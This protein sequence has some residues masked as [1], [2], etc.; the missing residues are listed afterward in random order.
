MLQHQEKP[1]IVPVCEQEIGILYQDDCLV[2][3]DKPDLLLSIP[4]KH[5]L[6]RDSVLTRL[7]EQ[8]N[9]VNLVHRLDL[10]TSG[11]LVAALSKEY[12]AHLSAQFAAR[13]VDKTYTAVLYG[14]LE[15]SQ[16]LIDLPIIAD[17]PNRPLQKI[18]F[19]HGKASQTEYTLLHYDEEKNASRVL[20]K[21]ITGRTHQ[22][23][24]HAREIGHP[25][26]GCD[27]YAHEQAYRQSP[28]L[29]L[30]ANS[31]TFSHPRTGERMNLN[32]NVPF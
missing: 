4:G 29:L 26:L 17:W 1:Y 6:N 27:M 22:L 19:E 13:E 21:P 9:W 14:R 32:S 12:H 24:I 5:P 28:R 3:V 18:C 25:I 11:I 23:R 8:F 16:G 10:D 20:F 15:K 31:I 2:V 30:H 7:R